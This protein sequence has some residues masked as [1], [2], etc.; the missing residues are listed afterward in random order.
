APEKITAI[1]L[2]ID[3]SHFRPSTSQSTKKITPYVLFVGTWDAR[4]NIKLLI[5]AFLQIADQIPHKLIIAG[6]PA[7][8]EDGSHEY[9]QQSEYT[10]RIEFRE[11]VDYND[12]PGLYSNADLFV[13]PSAYEGWG[14]PPQEAMA[15]GTPV[16]VSNG[17]S[18]PEVVGDAGI[19]IPFSEQDVHARMH[20]KDFTRRLAQ[21]MLSIL[22]SPEKQQA[23]IA[24]GL[25]QASKQSW[26][27]VV[28]QTIAV[29]KNL[30]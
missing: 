15:C 8:K 7:H 21:E 25:V 3:T 6:K 29:Y 13:F 28:D 9:A 30:L 20:D 2:A 14:F 19:V 18:L 17:G 11:Q 12:L 26:Q 27:S 22:T 16:V 10:K 5:D 24:K 4:K 23:M 1:P